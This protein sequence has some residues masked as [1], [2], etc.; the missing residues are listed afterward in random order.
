MFVFIVPAFAFA[1]SNWGSL[2][3]NQDNWYVPGG[4]TVIVDGTVLASLLGYTDLKVPNATVI[5]AGTS[6]ATTTDANGYFSLSGVTPGNYTVM[7]SADNLGTI[8]KAVTIESG[9]KT[10]VD[11]PL[12][13]FSCEGL[14]TQ[15]DLDQALID[16]RRIWDIGG[17]G[18]VGLPEAIRALQVVSGM[19]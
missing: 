13:T 7:I 15:D 14:Y 2:V 4:E 6:F 10:I 19:R 1:S 5:L 9:G 8:S 3:W 17:D 12:M 18:K 16:E 11:I